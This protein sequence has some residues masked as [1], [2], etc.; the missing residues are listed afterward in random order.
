MA[1]AHPAVLEAITTNNNVQTPGYGED[2][3][4]RRARALILQECGLSEP[5]QDA[6][7][8]DPASTQTA[9]AATTVTSTQTP[10]VYFLPGGTQ[11]NASV[12][13]ALLRRAEAVICVENSH[14]NVHE[15]GAIELSGHKVIALPAHEGKMDARELDNYLTQFYADDTWTHMSIPGA[16]YITFP[17]EFGTLYTKAELEAIGEVCRRFKLPL[18]LDG[19]RLGYGLAASQDVTLRDIARI[20]DVFYIGGTKMGLLFGEAVVVKDAA[21]MPNFFTLIKA[22][23]AVTAKGRLLGMQFETLFTDGLYLQIGRHGVQLAHMLRDGLQKA[24]YKAFVDSPTNQQFFILPNT[25]IDRL[26]PECSFEY[27]GPRGEVESKVRFV[28]SWETTQADVEAFLSM[29]K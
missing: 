24:G 16:V 29:L 5:S 11:T 25:L 27:W 1:G 15:A 9:P 4:C 12:L 10:A 2:E 13:D 6:T 3:F 20:C 21:M 7:Q 17:T 19:A 22:R 28:T 14:I 18:Y 26:L 8:A 23:G